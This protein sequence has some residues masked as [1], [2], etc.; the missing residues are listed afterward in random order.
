MP[1]LVSLIFFSLLYIYIVAF[2]SC[3]NF[4][5]NNFC[6]ALK[7]YYQMIL[8]ANWTVRG[9]G[10]SV[11]I[12]ERKCLTDDS[13][14]WNGAQL[15][16]TTLD[17]FHPSPDNKMLYILVWEKPNRSTLVSALSPSLWKLRKSDFRVGRKKSVNALITRAVCKSH[18]PLLFYFFSPRSIG[19]IN[20]F[21]LTAPHNLLRHHYLPQKSSPRPCP[22][23]SVAMEMNS[24][25]QRPYIRK[26]NLTVSSNSNN[27]LWVLTQYPG[28]SSLTYIK[29][30]ILW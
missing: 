15:Y 9:G 18:L 14:S 6:L 21:I 13:A 28:R 12:S 2:Y 20:G 25:W 1:L 22:R 29:C 26:S 4:L 3:P 19:L 27:K 23:P 10:Q 7:K 30:V 11:A 5:Q 24:T 8:F 16:N 17:L